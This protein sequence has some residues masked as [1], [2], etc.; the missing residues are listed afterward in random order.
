MAGTQRVV[1]VSWRLR[2]ALA[3]MDRARRMTGGRFDASVA[4]VLERIGEHG[5]P[6]GPEAEPATATDLERPRPVRAPAAP[7]DTGGIGKGLALRWAAARALPML[8]AGAGLLLDAGGDVLAAGEPP[9]DG[10]QVGIED[11]AARGADAAPLAVVAIGRGAIATSSVRVR[12][13]R[14]P[15][16]RAVHHLIDPATRAP[17]TTGLLAVTVAA[18][19]P[20]WAEVW[21]KDLFLVGRGRIGDEARAR[22][23]A[24]WWVDTDGHLG[25]TPAARMQS[26]WVA[27]ARLG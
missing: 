12:R 3:I 7:V 26:P 15:D 23:L 20:A 24:A 4:E 21:T 25:M 13:W 16:G 14:G 18:A 22:G 10:W 8:G 1:A 9:S 17:A 11:P 27:E 6:L 5:A 2:E 19:D